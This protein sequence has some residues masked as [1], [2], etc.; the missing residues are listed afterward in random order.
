MQAGL[1]AMIG[2][3]QAPVST[4]LVEQEGSKEQAE[5]LVQ[6]QQFHNAMQIAQAVTADI[7]PEQ[8]TLLAEQL[9][10]ASAGDVQ[11]VVATLALLPEVADGEIKLTQ[12]QQDILQRVEFAAVARELLEA[13]AEHSLHGSEATQLSVQTFPVEEV[14]G[15]LPQEEALA[16][17]PLEAA[18][19]EEIKLTQE[20]T[21]E[22]LLV[23][24]GL[25]DAD[26]ENALPLVSISAA[27]APS[28]QANL[29]ERK[30]DTVQLAS[31]PA[32]RADVNAGANSGAVSPVVDELSLLTDADLARLDAM[33]EQIGKQTGM[34]S[35][36]TGNAAQNFAEA[37]AQNVTASTDTLDVQQVST[38][39]AS[40]ASQQT[41]SQDDR[42]GVRL[43]QATPS[44]VNDGTS[45]PTDQVKVSIQQAIRA[46]HDR[47]TVQ[48]EP[49][50]LGRI[51]IRLEA[52]QDGRTQLLVQADNRDTLDLLQRD[53][54]SL[55]LA[56][57][58][59]G[60]EADTQDMAFNLSEGNGGEGE[61]GTNDA[62]DSKQ[63]LQDEITA[64][65][66]LQA[67]EA[68]AT[69]HYALSIAQGLDIKV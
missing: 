59:A 68:E 36:F 53:A 63:A 41:A 11:E 61:T 2:G 54:K 57:Q 20:E 56:L 32:M 46:G 6:S 62:K 34:R 51:E 25:S 64:D 38:L 21:L 30:L 14:E 43:S 45:P 49:A 35:N 7:T 60:L 4:Q 5:K 44:N 9:Q 10:I 8:A 52:G 24:Q 37:I 26:A 69:S 29:Q 15:A 47:I 1:L 65:E 18:Q 31:T 22:Q 58:E 40:H 33:I 23:L 67:Q 42:L 13:P 55:A 39:S 12:A 48:L 27:L 50:E 16:L 19:M 3:S 28:W 66:H 17:L